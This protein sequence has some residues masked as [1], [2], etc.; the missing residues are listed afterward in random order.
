MGAIQLLY[1]SVTVDSF[2]SIIVT[3]ALT[4]QSSNI[5]LKGGKGFVT[6]E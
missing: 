2:K 1:Y 6:I 3:F 5:N 4:T